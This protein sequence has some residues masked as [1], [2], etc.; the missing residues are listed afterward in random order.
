VKHTL[1]DA[2]RE[3]AALHAL[4]AL[5]ADEAAAFAAHLREGCAA[6]A[7]EVASFKT[8]AGDLALIA[9]PA[10][11][12]PALRTRVLER[13]ARLSTR[14]FHFRLGDEGEWEE[15]APG[16]LRRGLSA[17]AYLI[18]LA[19]GCSI[20]RHRH[21]VVE[22]CY[23]LEGDLLVADRRLRAGDYHEAPPGTLHDGLV[24]DEGCL[25]LVVEAGVAGPA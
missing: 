8:V 16:V 2:D 13:V 15:L 14:R 7:A 24:S 9:P 3:R 22:H 21:T 20:P 1:T 5:D 11:P 25:F 18:R 10:V 17:E 12:S 23:V 6:C 19:P 4:D